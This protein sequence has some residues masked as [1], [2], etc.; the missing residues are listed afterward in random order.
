MLIFLYLFLIG[1][2]A[3][4]IGSIIGIGGGI[5]IVPFLS[6]AL[7]VPIHIAIGTS[8][9]A[10]LMTSL[11][12]SRIF[13]KKNT[14]NI[15]LGLTL[16]I[17]TTFGGIIGSIAVA[18]LKNKVLF[19]I[20]GCFAISAGIFT[21]FKNT[22]FQNKNQR[23]NI[24]TTQEINTS[25][26]SI[27][28]SKYYDETTGKAYKYK[29]KNVLYGSIASLFAGLSSGLLGVGG[30]VIKVPAMNIFMN[31]PIKVATATSNYMIGITAVVSSIIYFYNGYINP[32]ITIP[33]VI[34][35]LI[36]ATTGSFTAEKL[37]SSQIVIII[38]TIFIAIGILMFLRAFN[39]IAY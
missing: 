31:V 30:G 36:G 11:T 19:I 16:E 24:T 9:I 25:K 23:E 13:L 6:L 12:A 37:K 21:Y 2:A 39:V 8:I 20:F 14:T 7:K 32:F 26:D 33:V 18:Y 35:V 17:P 22:Y 10:V 38:L 27:F 3:G 5:I 29:V 15:E 34:G 4:L 28:D 1:L